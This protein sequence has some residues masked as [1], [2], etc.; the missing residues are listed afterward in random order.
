MTRLPIGWTNFAGLFGGVALLAAAS[1]TS[2]DDDSQKSFTQAA[3]VM[4][5]QV[6]GAE[7]PAPQRANIDWSIGT[8]PEWIWGTPEPRACVLKTTFPGGAQTARLK[9][10]CDNVMRLYLNGKLVASSSEWKDP[11][12]VDVLQNLKP[13][14]NELVAEVDNE[15]DVG[16]FILKLVLQMSDGSTQYVVSGSDWKGARTRDAQ[17]WS[18]ARVIGKLGDGPWG[19]VLKREPELAGGVP[20]DVFE[21]PPGF[22]VERLFTV[23][24]EELGSW[25][26]IAV[27]PK[28]RIIASD[29][30][31]KGL[32][33]ITPAGQSRESTNSS[34][35]ASTTVER[36]NLDISAAQ[37]LLFAFGHLYISVNGGKG[38]GLYRAT[39]D[40]AADAFGPVEKLRDFRGGGEHGPHA[41]RLSPDGESIYVIAGNHTDPPF[42]VPRSAPPQTMGSVRSEVLKTEPLP[43][44][45]SSRILTNWDEDLLLPRVWDARGHARGKL[46][47]GGWIARTDLEGKTWELFSVGYRNPYD[48][49]FNA[50]GELFAYDADMEWDMGMPWYRPTRVVHATSG[51]EFGWR[52][53]SGKWPTYYLDSL[54]PVVEIGPGSPVG[55]EFGYGAKFPARFQKALFLCDWTFGTMYAIHLTPD[56]SSYIG[57]KEEFLSRT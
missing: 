53:G 1:V 23:P 28:G 40:E 39:Y 25:V 55:V 32:C 35:P 4:P 57:E 6:R 46:A 38:S 10:T 2:A 50:D 49:A 29:Q 48:M 12:E 16:G 11:V 27:D 20:R 36:L 17:E 52:S 45:A 54:P 7:P 47:P 30:G 33:R 51:S 26:C 31:D 21:V 41:L 22:H 14:D 43:E 24:K 44:G 9:A 37:G 18:P 19:D 13:G 34:E 42:D 8:R 56:G 15:G 3:E 5:A